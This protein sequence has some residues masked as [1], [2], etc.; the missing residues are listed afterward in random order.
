MPSRNNWYNALLL[1][2]GN[3]EQTAIATAKVERGHAKHTQAAADKPLTGW[4][5]QEA[6]TPQ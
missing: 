3:R 5:D 6:P 1:V 4:L 2:T